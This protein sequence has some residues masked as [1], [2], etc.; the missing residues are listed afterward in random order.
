MWERADGIQGVR[1]DKWRQRFLTDDGFARRLELG[2][3]ARK[4]LERAGQPV[5]RT[6]TWRYCA[7]GRRKPKALT[8]KSGNRQVA[9]VFDR[10]GHVA[11]IGSTLHKHRA[12]GVRPGTFAADLPAS[13]ERVSA[14][15]YRADADNGGSYFFGVRGK[16]V[17]YVGVASTAV[18][19]SATL[20]AYI[21]RARL[22]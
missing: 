20:R 6:R 16:R 12:G 4:V 5:T 14:G 19:R 13:A 1:C 11:L 17:R 10:G 8:K 2:M 7:N 3:S 22:N 21:R 18:D 9:A 15:L